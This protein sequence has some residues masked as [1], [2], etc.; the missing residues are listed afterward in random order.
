M[1]NGSPRGGVALGL[2]RGMTLMN[3][4]VLVSICALAVGLAL[5]TDFLVFEMTAEGEWERAALPALV[6][7]LAGILPVAVL[8]WRMERA[9]R[10]A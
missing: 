10:A 4:N 9:A 7:V 2:N 1:T 3:N 5:F 8:T 6:I